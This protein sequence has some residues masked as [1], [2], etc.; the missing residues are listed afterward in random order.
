MGDF[1]KP[2]SSKLAPKFA[3]AHETRP[4]PKNDRQRV[5]YSPYE[6]GQYRPP[7][8]PRHV[9]QSGAAWYARFE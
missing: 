6:P 1:K 8:L 2:D 5:V 3:A 7:N 9:R 4:R